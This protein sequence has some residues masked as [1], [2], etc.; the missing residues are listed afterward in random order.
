MR[1]VIVAVLAATVGGCGAGQSGLSHMSDAE[2]EAAMAKN[3]A[4]HECQRKYPKRE[5][6]KAAEA[7]RCVNTA[8]EG[9]LGPNQDLVR[10][11]GLRNLDAAERYD[12]GKLSETQMDLEL[13]SIASAFES[14]AQ[15]RYAQTAT[16][17]AAQHQAG[18]QQQAAD[19]QRSMALIAAG[20]R[21]MTPPPSVSCSTFGGITTCR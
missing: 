4:L 14:Q 5:R 1:V 20:A 11:T 18:A 13:A 6:G 17:A 3:S 7:I 8:N 21:M 15:A 9:L 16:A 12:A 19:Q 2:V 10:L